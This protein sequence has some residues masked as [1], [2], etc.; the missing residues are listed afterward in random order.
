MLNIVISSKWR[1]RLFM[2]MYAL[3]LIIYSQVELA[4]LKLSKHTPRDELLALLT[5]TIEEKEEQ[6]RFSEVT[7]AHTAIISNNDLV[8]RCK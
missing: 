7:Y 1:F 2:F 3:G 6:V 4:V 5:K 8:M